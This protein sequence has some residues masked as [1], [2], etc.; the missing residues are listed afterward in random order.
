M[1]WT[2]KRSD[3]SRTEWKNPKLYSMNMNICIRTWN[4]WY[5]R[6][7]Y[8]RSVQNFIHTLACKK[9]VKW[10]PQKVH[11][12]V[13]YIFEEFWKQD[14][15]LVTTVGVPCWQPKHVINQHTVAGMSHLTIARLT[16]A[17]I[18]RNDPGE[19]ERDQS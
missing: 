17:I 19:R 13:A 6:C 15:G 16:Y 18:H 12:W 7:I 2:T 8:C 4:I 3:N 14:S 11:I 9:T 5:C 10:E 1:L